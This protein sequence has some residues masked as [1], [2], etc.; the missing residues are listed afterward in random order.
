MVS[1][2]LNGFATQCIHG[3]S[4][5]I[6]IGGIFYENTVDIHTLYDAYAWHQSAS[7]LAIWSP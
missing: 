4:Q 6:H 5:L 2:K 7:E 1:D 3:T